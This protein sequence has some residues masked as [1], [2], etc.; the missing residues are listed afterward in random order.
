M[1]DKDEE[2]DSLLDDLETAERINFRDYPSTALVVLAAVSSGLGWMLYKWMG[3][4][5]A[6]QSVIDESGR[7][8]EP[9]PPAALSSG[10]PPTEKP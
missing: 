9:T 1:P 2:P 10:E 3:R 5:R 6:A 4:K 7:A 8:K